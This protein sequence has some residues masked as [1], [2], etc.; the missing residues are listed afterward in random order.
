MM[1]TLLL[2]AFFT[3]SGFAESSLNKNDP[4]YHIRHHWNWNWKNH[5]GYKP[6]EPKFYYGYATPYKLLGDPPYWERRPYGCKPKQLY[7]ILR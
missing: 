3:I 7:I 1:K 4:H 5:Y 6:K 2:F